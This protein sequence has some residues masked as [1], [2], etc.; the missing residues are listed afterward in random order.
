MLAIFHFHLAQG[1][2]LKSRCH[3]CS[4]DGVNVGAFVEVM[5]AYDWSLMG[6]SHD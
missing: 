1:R 4:H 3:H 2:R 5:A 6:E